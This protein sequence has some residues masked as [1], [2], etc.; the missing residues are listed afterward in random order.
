MSD[1]PY[2]KL[3]PAL[4]PKFPFFSHRTMA[5]V[6][7]AEGLQRRATTLHPYQMMRLKELLQ[8]RPG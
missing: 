3:H 1:D 8:R 6:A 4:R 7:E 5:E 2:E